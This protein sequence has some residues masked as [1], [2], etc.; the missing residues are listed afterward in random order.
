MPGIHGPYESLARY[1]DFL[2]S[3]NLKG[4]SVDSV[5]WRQMPG[6]ED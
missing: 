1:R 3:L 4:F 5:Q 6:Q 2:A